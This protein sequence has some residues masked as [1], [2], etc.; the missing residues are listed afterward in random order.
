MVYVDSSNVEAIGFDG[1]TRELWVQFVGGK[2]YIYSD[3]PEEVHAEFMQADS[4]GSYLNRE[5]KPNYEC[6]EA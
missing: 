4:K 6:R 5:L 1:E 3:V 2:A